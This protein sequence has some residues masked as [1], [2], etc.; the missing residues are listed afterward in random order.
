MNEMLL[1]EKTRVIN[2]KK[3]AVNKEPKNLMQK[4]E[5]LHTEIFMTLL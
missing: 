1:V 2:A 4:M 3:R 5:K